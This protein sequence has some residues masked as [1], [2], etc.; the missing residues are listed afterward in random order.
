MKKLVS[1]LLAV[2]MLVSIMLLTGCGSSGGIK[3][4]LGQ[5]VSI[6]KSTDATADKDG[7]AQVDVVMAAVG[8]DSKGKI[9]SVTIDTA[10]TRVAFDA[11][12]KIKSDLQ[13]KPKTKVELGKDYGMIKQSSIGREWYEQIAELEKWMV[14]K[15]IDQVKA[16]KVKAVDENHPSVPDEPDLT[17]KVTISVEDY[18]AAVEEAVKNAK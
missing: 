16:M 8:V 17:S 7:V 5:T 1:A 10:Q 12:G 15:T 14:G 18:I 9:V 6:A 2:L 11:Q 13:E 3:T 4:G